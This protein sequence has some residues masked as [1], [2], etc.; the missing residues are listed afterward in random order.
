[1]MIILLIIQMISVVTLFIIS[2]VNYNKLM[3]AIEKLKSIQ[4]DCSDKQEILSNV[5]MEE[6]THEQANEEKG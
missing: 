1:M 4:E 3:K 2:L 5:L 6:L